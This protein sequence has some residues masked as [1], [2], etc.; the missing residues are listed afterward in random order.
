M[1]EKELDKEELIIKI[2]SKLLTVKQFLSFEKLK[3]KP[4]DN[5]KDFLTELESYKVYKFTIEVEP[6]IGGKESNIWAQ[7]I[8]LMYKKYL[9]GMC[10]KYQEIEN[11]LIIEKTGMYELL[12]N[13]TGIHRVQRV[14]STDKLGRLQ[15]STA[16]VLVC[17]YVD[18]EDISL[19]DL[20]IDISDGK[21]RGPGGQ[22]VNKRNN[23][24]RI[25][26]TITNT[27]LRV[28]GRKKSEN[29]EEAKKRIL[30]VVKEKF[31]NEQINLQ[32]SQRDS[33]NNKDRSAKIR[34]YSYK[35][36]RIT[37]HRY[38]ISTKELDKVIGG[39]LDILLNKM[40]SKSIGK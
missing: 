16:S 21:G 1:S 2:R 22:H 19:E 36:N 17:P 29:L 40:N 18:E 7:D 35:E 31:Q 8:Q 33:I 26:D 20:D 5:L 4:V 12:E 37:D 14:P 3:D 27:K 38:N 34:T 10:I 32:K 23:M 28:D 30:E 6:G 9:D 24:I 15:T 25:H 13:E 11:T 39:K